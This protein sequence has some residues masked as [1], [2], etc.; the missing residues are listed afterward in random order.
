MRNTLIAE[1]SA[2]GS[3]PPQLRMEQ[4]PASGQH[5]SVIPPAQQSMPESDTAATSGAW[6]A[7]SSEK[8]RKA[9]AGLIDRQQA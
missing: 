8:S 7:A 9:A 3:S 6:N 5:I 4:A 1:S 2:G